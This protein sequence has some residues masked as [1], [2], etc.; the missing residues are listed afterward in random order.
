MRDTAAVSTPVRAIIADDH[1][2]VLLAIE[3]L[4]SGYPNMEI[5][6]RAADATELFA[7]V[8][9][10]S[11]D[12]VLMDLYMPGGSDGSGLEVVRQFKTRY[13]DIA[14]VVLTM[15]TEAAELQKVISLGVEGLVSKRDRIDLIHVAVITAL[16]RECY[17]GPAVRALIA[18][19]SATQRL[20]YV[21]K[22][23]SRRELEV[24]TQ[25]AS[26]YGVTEIAARLERSVKT[27]SAQK[28]TAM[29]KLALHSDAEL[30]RF[31]VEYGVIPEERVP[32]RQ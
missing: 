16:A 30:F 20:D 1:P 6:G 12:L 14:L 11:C 25:Y 10:G 7:E 31:A 18:D 32:K 8:D 17:V 21:R 15:E 23:L 4:I 3:N 2:L 19:A 28:C 26:G 13:P 29:R 9:R 27:I 22:I 5:V 24:F